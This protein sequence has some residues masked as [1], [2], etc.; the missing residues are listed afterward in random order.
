MPKSRGARPRQRVH[1]HR[2]EHH[3]DHHRRLGR[4]VEAQPHDHDRG[5]T[6]DRQGRDQ[7]ADR[8]QAA[9]AGRAS[10]RWRWRSRTP[11][12]AADAHSRWPASTFSN[13]LAENRPDRMLGGGRRNGRQSADG[14]GSR[15]DGTSNAAH[16]QFPTPKRSARPNSS[17]TASRA[18]R[19]GCATRIRRLQRQA[20][21]P[22]ELTR[23]VPPA[24]LSCRRSGRRC[25]AMAASSVN[26]A[27]MA[28]RPHAGD[29]RRR[30]DPGRP[31]VDQAPRRAGRRPRGP[32]RS[33]RSGRNRMP[34]SSLAPRPAIGAGR[35]LADDG[36]D[37]ADGDGHLHRGEEVTAARLA[38]AASTRICSPRRRCRSVHQVEM[39]ALGTS[40][41]PG[42][43]R[44]PP[45]R[46]LR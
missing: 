36:A 24:S 30:A 17:G 20:R 12:R 3:D 7:I 13:G 8:Q 19:P 6:D 15:T 14:G 23:A 45:E 38:S 41:G 1:Q 31:M 25:L 46:T 4:P 40:A 16:H 10:G 37:Q 5:D 9:S 44:P 34:V 27:V 29:R 33:A 2:K 43:C 32:T 42:P 11:R 39:L 26:T 18:S 28:W 22:R 35:Q 21:K